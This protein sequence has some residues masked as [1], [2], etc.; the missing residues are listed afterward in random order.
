MFTVS[1][2]VDQDEVGIISLLGGRNGEMSSIYSS[3]IGMGVSSF[4]P[5]QT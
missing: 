2:G 1:I 4:I 5:F 3:F